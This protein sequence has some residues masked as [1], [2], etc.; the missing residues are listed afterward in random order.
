MSG[1]GD[2]A[3][4]KSVPESE[5][6]GNWTRTFCPPLRDPIE[7]PRETMRQRHLAEAKAVIDSAPSPTQDT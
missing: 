5:Y 6:E 3:R 2:L 1:K 4:P 7:D